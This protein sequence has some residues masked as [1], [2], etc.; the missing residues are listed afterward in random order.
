MARVSIR[1]EKFKD[2]NA[3]TDGAKSS[4][5]RKE[6][7]LIFH[8]DW[9]HF[10][11]EEFHVWDTLLSLASYVNREEL[12]YPLE[13]ISGWCRVTTE[14]FLVALTKLAERESINF[15]VEGEDSG[16][17]L[18][19]ARP[20]NGPELAQKCATTDVRTDVRTLEQAD[21]EKVYARYPNKKGKSKGLLACKRQIKTPED[22]ASLA[23]AVENYA[24]E[25]RR[26]KTE[27]RY[28]KHFATFMNCWRDY[29]PDPPQLSL[30]GQA[31]FELSPEDEAR[32]REASLAKK[33]EVARAS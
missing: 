22:L 5:Y 15:E 6:H 16:P 12:S 28:I 8:P 4:W 1:I 29:I 25:C 32:R 21:F 17:S 33:A 7:S 3:R 20:K 26:E 31:P 14:V 24:A 9:S 2:Y 10:T 27:K 11:A 19:Q 18:A 23:I 13:Q 30:E